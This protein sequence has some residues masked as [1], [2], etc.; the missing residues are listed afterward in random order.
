M[1]VGVAVLPG[2]LGAQ[3]FE[4]GRNFP[5]LLH[6]NAVSL[7][8][9]NGDGHLDLVVPSWSPDRVAIY[10][11]DGA[12]GFA[13]AETYPVG[14]GP[15][16]ATTADF[17]NDGHPDVATANSESADISI[18]LNSGTGTLLPQTRLTAGATAFNVTT[19]DLNADGNVDLAASNAGAGTVSV[20]LGNGNG[21]FTSAGTLTAGTSP[22]SSAMADFDQDGKT[23]LAVADFGTNAIWVFPGNGSGGFG[24]AITYP[25]GT[26]PFTIAA[27]DLNHD[28]RIDIAV[29]NFG[30]A[31]VSVLRNNGAGGFVITT[32]PV[33]LSPRAVVAA[34]FNADGHPD[35]GVANRD[36]NTVSVLLGNGAGAFTLA[37]HFGVGSGPFHLATAD[38]DGDGVLD[39]VVPDRDGFAVTVLR[40]ASQGKLHAPTSYTVGVGPR[41]I[42][43]TDLDA[44]GKMDIVTVDVTSNT[45]S[46]LK[47]TGPGTV[48]APTAYAVATAPYGVTTGDFNEDGRL[49]IVSASSSAN[50]VSLLRAN[51][52]GGFLP[53]VHTTA[54]SG[55]RALVAGDFNLDG[56]LDVATANFNAGTVG[57]LLGN[58]AGA[59]AAA[60]GLPAGGTGPSGIAAADF[61]GDGRL[62]LASAN[63]NSNNV[64]VLLSTG[65]GTF[66]P[67]TAFATGVKP[68]GVAA[69]DLD[70]DG[71]A[72][73]AVT[74]ETSNTVSL[75][76]GNGA[77]GFVALAP[78][79]V[80]PRPLAVVLNE[81][82][83]DDHLD[84]AVACAT[85]NTISVASGNGDGTFAAPVSVDTGWFPRALAVADF[86]GDGR[87]DLAAG[88]GTSNDAW[89]L[90]NRSGAVTDLAVGVT[91][92][93]TFVQT[94]SP[95]AYDVTVTNLGPSVA[96]SVTLDLD[97]P[98][99]LQGVG[100]SVDAGTFDETTGAW[101]DLDLAASGSATLTVSG[102]VAPTAT[103][104][105][106]VEATV[107]TDGAIDPTS[108]NN[109]A[110]DADPVISGEADLAITI[111]DGLDTIAAGDPVTY[112]IVATN[113]GPSDVE[114]ANV[115][116]ALPASLQGV[117]WTCVGTGGASCSGAGTGTIAQAVDLPV[118]AHTTFTL[119]ATVDPLAAAGT[120]T[121]TAGIAAPSDIIDPE[122]GNN[123]GLDSDTLL[124]DAPPVP[125]PQSVTLV[126]D[127]SLPIT[128][129]ASDPDGDPL[130]FAIETAPAHGVLTGVAPNV[131]YT[132]QADY[133]GPDSFTFSAHDGTVSASAVVSITVTPVNDP[134][135]A[136]GQSVSTNEDVALGITLV[137]TDADGD[138]LVYTIVST[139]SLGSLTGSGAARTY[140]PQ[141]N[142]SGA[143]TFTFTV[144]DGHV[145]SPA[146]T[147]NVTVNAVNDP[148][149]VVSPIADLTITGEDT[150]ATVSLAGVF[151]DVESGAGGL[152]LTAT[153]SN[154]GLV[155]P[156]I[157]GGT[158][159]LA[160]APNVG[161]T[162]TVTVRATD[163]G[164]A[165]V[166]D[167]FVVTVI[168]PGVRINVSDANRG[169]GSSAGV[170]FTLTLSQPVAQTVTVAYQTVDGTATAPADYGALSG[171]VT[172]SPG[173]TS[174]TVKVT[175]V[176]DVIDEDDETFTLVLS[177][178]A[179]A[180]IEDGVGVGT[181]V[182]NDTAGIS[183]LDISVGEG[184]SGITPATFTIALS[185]PSTKQIT[186]N[187]ATAPVSGGATA[188]VDYVAQSGVLT[189]PAGSATPQTVTVDVLG[190][191][192]DENNEAFSLQL[193][194]AVNAT[195]TRALGRATI[196]DDDDPPSVTIADVTLTEGQSGTKSFV[197]TFTLSGVSAL[198]TRVR[199][200]TA[201]GT[202]TA[203]SD[204]T[205]RSGEI[206]FSPGVTSMTVAIA[207]AGDTAVEPDEGF[208]VNLN[209]PTNLTIGDAQAVGTIL[210]D[211]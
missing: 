91:N 42:A 33:G 131:V 48:G 83:G 161:G 129:T 166:E 28:G 192:I 76:L 65:P 151:T 168:R 176:G 154:P 134:P 19:G 6:P 94:G 49:D 130:T 84:I 187:F 15:R 102:T 180:T 119:H 186:V 195:I 51:G 196:L 57:L 132:P 18:L 40:G 25:V 2:L 35:L 78:L 116:T 122:P 96:A 147:V 75:L 207:V 13:A 165:F 137:G 71:R 153:S 126:E 142:V 125:N 105:F 61:N 95:V 8:D 203:G 32:M 198:T 109:S 104:T 97:L 77:G 118:G 208:F 107:A 204:Y 112:T 69:G 16:F 54:G 152:T 209:T 211:D 150:T 170:V 160:L 86:D 136:V 52:S 121:V 146:A 158:L 103:G 191:L 10:M 113:L 110:S 169:E 38:L 90:L 34:D 145:T 155:T 138:P 14:T 36:N 89:I 41:G 64:T 164:T 135:H 29:P 55:P 60:V 93:A 184:N 141:A 99:G 26:S 163:P 87:P 200:E 62:D 183:L 123:S 23:D 181:I 88:N 11:G 72:D 30:S 128:L 210:N 133:F 58:G 194:G 68:S 80:G 31:S 100:Y 59:F 46:V 206:V 5:A 124:G 205:A 37:G 157:A 66:G 50:K 67:A 139:P 185:V 174:R 22:H 101:T 179:N 39:V 20:Y 21:T 114:D 56:H 193:S 85:S 79:A 43:A 172:F 108:A 120:L 53:A 143:D 111:T 201:N 70:G 27:A 45:A 197:F 175:T 1:A 7:A 171:T 82:T 188:G 144:S 74:N 202:A 17:N 178:P 24:T 4:T 47:G 73:L 148:P 140:T 190:D 182:D 189:F 81:L 106:T 9:M 162:A 127:G 117:T 177:S 115:A 44:D 167:A 92:G 173:V 12:G 149:T 159:T 98:A 156:S 3:T 63:A 199:Y